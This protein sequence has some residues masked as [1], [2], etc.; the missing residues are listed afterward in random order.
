M[1]PLEVAAEKDR[2]LDLIQAAIVLSGGA[3]LTHD[4]LGIMPV[5]RLLGLIVCNGMGLSISPNR[6]CFEKCGVL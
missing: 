5:D 6:Q 2:L 4:A 1:D 3:K